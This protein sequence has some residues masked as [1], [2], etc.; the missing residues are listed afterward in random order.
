MIAICEKLKNHTGENNNLTL[1]NVVLMMFRI[2]RKIIKFMQ[3]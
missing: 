2:E 1:R 3:T